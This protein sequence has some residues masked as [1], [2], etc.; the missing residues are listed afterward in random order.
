M[1]DELT[2]VG[3]KC[4]EVVVPVCA[5]YAVEDNIP[6]IGDVEF[7]VLSTGLT[8]FEVPTLECCTINGLSGRELIN[9]KWTCYKALNPPTVSITLNSNCCEEIS[10]GETGLVPETGV[11]EA[12]Q[13]TLDGQSDGGTLNIIGCDGLPAVVEISGQ[14]GQG[15]QEVCMMRLISLQGDII[16]SGPFAVCSE[17]TG[18]ICYSYQ[19]IANGG[20]GGI[21]YTPCGSNNESVTNLDGTDYAGFPVRTT[22]YL[23]STTL[24]WAYGWSGVYPIITKENECNTGLL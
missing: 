17:N 19:I 20:N 13:V 23:C 1:V 9:G 5:E 7:T 15:S 3:V 6:E 21:K 24:P 12:Y 8:T 16:L 18:P 4:K 10:G 11:C 14:L 22:I 2:N